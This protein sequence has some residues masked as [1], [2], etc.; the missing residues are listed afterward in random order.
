M[1]D[2]NQLLRKKYISGIIKE[3]LPNYFCAAPFSQMVLHPNGDVYVCEERVGFL[4]NIKN[5]SLD[6]LW[7]GETI[8]SLRSEF[9]SG[10]LVQCKKN[11]ACKKCN[12]AHVENF[13]SSEFYEYIHNEPPVLNIFLNDDSENTALLDMPEFQKEIVE[14]AFPKLKKLSLKANDSLARKETF[15]LIEKL[16]ENKECRIS[17]T[18]TGQIEFDEEIKSQLSSA[19]IHKILFNIDSVFKD[20]FEQ[21]HPAQSL[22]RLLRTVYNIKTWSE[23]TGRQFD[24]MLEATI[25]LRI[26]NWKDVP[27]TY[28]FLVDSR[29]SSILVCAES[30]QKYSISGLLDENLLQVFE[31]YL[32]L[33]S[34]F[35]P[36]IHKIYQPLVEVLQLKNRPVFKKIEWL[37]NSRLLD[38][39]KKQITTCTLPFTRISIYPDGHFKPCCWLT[40]FNLTAVN[41]ANF[42]K[43][44]NGKPIKEIRKQF[45]D[46]N[47][48]VCKGNI[49][50]TSCNERN[51]LPEDFFDK[52]LEIKRPPQRL[53]LYFSGRCNLECP[54]CRNWQLKDEFPEVELYWE[55]LKSDVFQHLCEIE[56]L[57]GE[58][59]FQKRTF[60]LI[61]T[62]LEINPDCLWSFTTNGQLKFDGQIKTH[63]ERIRIANFSVSID[64]LKPEKFAK[65]RKNGHLWKTV[66]FLDALT[67][68]KNGLSIKLK[69]QTNI[70]FVLQKE[71]YEEL[72]EIFRF[73]YL[74]GVRLYIAPALDPQEISIYGLSTE[75]K[76]EILKN[77]EC[78]YKEFP[79]VSINAVN[80]I[81]DL[82]NCIGKK[83]IEYAAQ[84]LL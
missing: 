34:A 46:N 16:A 61:N 66:Q 50:K 29:M 73:S 78:L 53:Q 49:E 26:D 54:S 35:D 1:K 40:N 68:Y 63:I 20:T 25:A 74:K 5:K 60:Q 75:T 64:S 32:K 10:N 17:V 48:T 9:L 43:A 18:T 79:T 31:F 55:K 37:L 52:Q 44:W 70:N 57:G 47:Y 39:K 45:L 41:D 8:S 7:N 6:E 82:K 11:I 27:D 14:K 67:S 59:F 30:N 42:D 77:L 56:V 4:G 83:A 36:Y 24:L 13:E 12:F 23:E 15:R 19:N 51:I 3:N 65:L 58:P 2:V 71:N 33:D 22:S 80:L 76:C 81:R 28:K 72:N 21:I 62:V 38:A 84:D 69:F